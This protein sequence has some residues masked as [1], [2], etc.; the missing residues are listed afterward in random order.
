[1]PT[2][3]LPAQ[4]LLAEAV[5]R[6][7][8]R[9][10]WPNEV[11]REWALEGATGEGIGVCVLD[12]G[13]D[14]SHPAVGEIEASMAVE[15]GEDGHSWVREVGKSA[16]LFG[17]GT[18]CAGII[19]SIAPACRIASVRV[20]GK[21]N[22]GR[23]EVMAAG[24]GWAIEQGY[25]IV[26]MSL[27]TTRRDLSALLHELADDA[28]FQG[29][30]IV[31]SA[32]N[33]SVESLPWRFSSVFSVGSHE[34][35]DPLTF[36]SNPTPPVDFFAKGVDLEVAWLEGATISSAGNSFATAHLSGI[37]ALVLSKHPDLTQ[38]ELKSVLRQISDNVEG[39]GG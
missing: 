9:S 16:D 29:S 28:Y 11:T 10:S 3:S 8:M 20:L 31:A 15:R 12:S 5:P 33:R 22:K 36:Y 26:N 24:L 34:G 18:A 4:S 14:S 30:T 13:V 2:D 35:V 21:D 17:H 7:A 38:F 39:A 32:H 1:M 37:A 25:Q 27:S 23:G 19:R 6:I